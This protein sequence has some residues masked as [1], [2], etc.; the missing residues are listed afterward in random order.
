MR[1][2]ET[3]GFQTPA[4]KLQAGV[5]STIWA[6]RA[7]YD[8]LMRMD[9]VPICDGRSTESTSLQYGTL[10]MVDNT[11]MFADHQEDP[12]VK[13]GLLKI[14]IHPWITGKGVLEPGQPMQ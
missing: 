14:E 1:L 7:Y 10:C 4:S 3:L 5:A 12:T 9:Q 8:E 2:G 11:S 13:A 6:G